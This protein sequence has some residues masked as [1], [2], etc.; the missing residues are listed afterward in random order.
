MK[1]FNLIILAGGK[2]GAWCESYGYK[3]KAM[4]P[5]LGKPTV[6]WVIE[7]FSR[8]DYIDN[9]IIIGPKELRRLYSMRYVHRLLP[10][11]A[12]FMQNLFYAVFY[13][14]A[15]TYKFARAHNGYLISF[16]DAA[17]LTTGVINATLKTIAESDP[18][19]ALHYVQ[20]E[21]IARNGYPIENRSYF[22][23]CG[24]EYTGSNIYYVKKFSKLLKVFNDLRL[25]RGYRKEPQ[26]ILEHINYENEGISGVEEALSKRL[27]TA[28]KIFIS[29]F[30]EMGVDIDRGSDYEFAKAHFQKI[31][32]QYAKSKDKK[33]F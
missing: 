3:K 1:K 23:V 20:K 8:S 31:K 14:K 2:D 11:Q 9:I 18:G 25:L 28:L 29:P 30:A 26:K 32:Q 19:I 12:S 10:E 6:S 4:L 16:C 22:H 33:Y 21:T 15:S 17:F 7:A 27:S 24:K 5:L 13:I